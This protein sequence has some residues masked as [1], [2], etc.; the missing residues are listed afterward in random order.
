MEQFLTKYENE[1]ILKKLWKWVNCLLED[2]FNIKK[3][4]FITISLF[5]F[6]FLKNIVT[7]PQIV[8]KAAP[9]CFIT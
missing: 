1:Y 8:S 3:S 4:C 5:Q 6:F 2:D 7:V 9:N